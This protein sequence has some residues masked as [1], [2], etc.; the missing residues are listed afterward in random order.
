MAEKICPSDAYKMTF[1]EAGGWPGN[2]QIAQQIFW[3]TAFTAALTKPGASCRERR[4]HTQV[5][6]GSV[7]SRRLLGE[8]H[9]TGLPGRRLLDFFNQ[10]T[11]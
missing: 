10:H 1:S 2:G 5:A 3:Y 9:E 4:W 11:A 7:P 6:H 8:R